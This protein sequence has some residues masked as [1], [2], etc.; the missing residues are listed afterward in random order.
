MR[1]SD[2]ISR[3]FVSESITIPANSEVILEGKS[4]QSEL[5]DTRYASVEP[6]SEK[7]SNILIFRCLVDPFKDKIP[8]RVANLENFPVKLMK[9]VLLGKMHPVIDYEQVVELDKDAELC[10]DRNSRLVN[11][12]CSSDICNLRDEKGDFS[13]PRI[14]FQWSSPVSKIQ[15]VYTGDD[16]KGAD[17]LENKAKIP[18]LPDHLTE[19]EKSCVNVKDEVF[20]QKLAEVLIKNQQAFAKNKLELGTCSIVKHRINTGNAIPVRQPLRR[21]PKAFEGEEE[22]YLKDQLEA[23]VITPSKSSWASP[24]VLVRKKD[25]TVRWC[26]DFRRVND[27]NVSNWFTGYTSKEIE[28]IQREDTELGRLHKW[29]DTGSCPT[30]DQVVQY[31]PAIR[32]YWLNFNNIELVE[33]VLYQ[34]RVH[35]TGTSSLQI[36]VP[37]VLRQEVITMCHDHIFGAHMGVSKTIEKLKSQFH[38]YC[39]GI[40]VKSHIKHCPVCNRFKKSKKPRASLQN[41]IVGH[42]WTE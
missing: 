16:I 10:K 19:L 40:D 15:Q 39:M 7:T 4:H 35:S 6:C 18:K 28:A 34:K 37:K 33:G 23:G 38:W 41:F 14:P 31:S 12:V 30:R 17:S 13:C 9:N 24:V 11:R 32:K 27:V 5:I 29:K 22:K 42:Q 20:K 3:V 21:T 1:R 36:L 26:I 8:V 2:N 25:K